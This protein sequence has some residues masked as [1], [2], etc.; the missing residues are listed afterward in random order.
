MLISQEAAVLGEHPVSSEQQEEQPRIPRLGKHVTIGAT[1]GLIAGV[2]LPVVCSLL[3]STALQLRTIVPEWI[4]LA[5][6]AFFI[7]GA[8]V[9][10]LLWQTKRVSNLMCRLILCGLLILWLCVLFA[11]VG[12]FSPKGYK[13]G[14]IAVLT[15]LV[16][17][18]ASFAT[19]RALSVVL[20]R[21]HAR[22]LMTAILVAATATWIVSVGLLAI[23][24]T[25]C[26]FPPK[27]QLPWSE[28]PN[29]LLIVLDTVRADHMSCYGYA[30]NTTPNIDAFAAEAHLYKNV[31]S[32][33][34]WTLPSHASFFTGL[35]SSGHLCTNLHMFLDDS[36]DTLAEQLNAAGYQTLA[37]VTNSALSKEQGFGQGFEVFENPG[38][39]IDHFR[40]LLG[41]TNRE[42]MDA[43]SY[44]YLMQRRLEEWFAQDYEPDRPFFIFLN[45]IEPHIPYTPPSRQLKWA[46][47]DMFRKWEEFNQFD[48]VFSY[49][50]GYEEASAAQDLEELETLYDEEIAYVDEKV[51]QAFE[52]LRKTGNY[53]NTLI[54]VTSDHGE[55]L[56]EHHLMEHQFSLYEQLVRVPLIVK[57]RDRFPA[58]EDHTFVQSHDIYPT[59]LGLAGI[60]WEPLPIHNCRSLLHSD[61]SETRLGVS[62]Y[63]RVKR[64]IDMYEEIIELERLSLHMRDLR[65]FQL[66]DMKLILSSREEA[67]LYNV[68]DDPLENHNLFG[69]RPDTVSKLD[70]Q[71]SVWCQPFTEYSPSFLAGAEDR[72]LSEEQ[73]ETMRG[74]G[75]IR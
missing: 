58:G 15:V 8:G 9:G 45:Y 2:I 23:S 62:E 44:S 10:A 28:R 7:A 21:G 32:P 4:A 50:F 69:L 13:I 53:D 35:P 38:R 75:Y 1:L 41:V 14:S 63:W 64:V 74:L 24:D 29:V 73:L 61:N 34:P 30:R 3:G 33:S 40:P 12:N 46:T 65:A 39:N 37:L 47:Q 67:E 72:K 57:Y 71:I 59:I 52:L 55:H 36:F 19:L 26:S 22:R 31:L 18:G 56:G 20:M 27:V 5:A 17:G 54:I 60:R 48:Y 6:P 16:I 49:S 68:N 66:G 11:F 51:G 70:R 42:E 43:K 25:S